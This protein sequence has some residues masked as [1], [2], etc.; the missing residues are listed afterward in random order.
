M[1]NRAVKLDEAIDTIREVLASGG[2]F[3]LFPRGR[4]MKPH[5]VQDRDSVELIAALGAR[6][7]KN[8]LAFYQRDNG[9]YVLHRVMKVN[10]DGTYD[11]CGDNQYTLER[12][13]TDSHIIGKVKTVYRGDRVLSPDSFSQKLYRALWCNMVIR[14]FVFLFIRAA[15]KFKRIFLRIFGK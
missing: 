3:R 15:R 11:M 4:S 2:T 10:A 1:N 5:I 12:G 8:E 7:A 14:N 13:I 6:L 9:Q